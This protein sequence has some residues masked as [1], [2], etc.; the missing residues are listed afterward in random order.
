MNNRYAA[1]D[2]ATQQVIDI[3]S[4]YANMVA[5][6]LDHYPCSSLYA[7]AEAIK[8]AETRLVNVCIGTYTEAHTAPERKA[9]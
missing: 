4:R 9:S 1:I 5:Q 8:Q 2:A 3:Q 6:G 7:I